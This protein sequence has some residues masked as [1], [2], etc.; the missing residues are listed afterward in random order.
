MTA[1]VTVR[2]T[3]Q[4]TERVATPARPVTFSVVPITFV[5]AITTIPPTTG[6]N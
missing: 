2:A 1:E 3:S 6:F 4:V 5:V